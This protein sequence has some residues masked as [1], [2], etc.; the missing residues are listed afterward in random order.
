MT[1]P[2]PLIAPFSK[3]IPE[4]SYIGKSTDIGTTTTSFNF[5]SFT[6]P[7]AGLAIVGV[8]GRYI[9]GVNNWNGLT[10]DGNAAT[11]LTPDLTG[12]TQPVAIYAR[13]LTAGGT[14]N[15]T[16]QTA[17]NLYSASCFVAFITGG[18]SATP[19]DSDEFGT[20]SI[21]AT[22]T[23]TVDIAANSIVLNVALF[24]HRITTMSYSALTEDD[25]TTG[26]YYRMTFGHLE[27]DSSQ[28]GYGL[29]ST[30]NT[31][32]RCSMVTAVL[33]LNT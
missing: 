3:I 19:T 25:E 18:I 15:V 24:D 28:T 32:A 12:G 17:A 22:V 21:S 7:S 8:G 20:D 16:G 26:T 33:S 23:N 5:G 10:I 31:A 11:K 14:F 13:A 4:Y 27:F 9:S 2:M 30:A 29:T 6:F 1:F